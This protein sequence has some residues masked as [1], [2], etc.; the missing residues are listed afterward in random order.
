M[1]ET[2]ERLPARVTMPL[3]TLITQQSLDEDYLHAAERRA[4]GRSGRPAPEQASPRRRRTAAL[5]VLAVFGV[6]VTTAA[7]QT[8]RNEDVADASRESLVAQVQ[9]QQDA[10]AELADRVVQLRERTASLGDQVTDTQSTLQAVEAE[11]DVLERTTGYA[12]VRGP[13]VRIVVD[14][15]EQGDER[16]RKED[17]FLVINGLWQAG[18]EAIALNG[19]RLS[20]VTSINNSDVAINV[21]SS[22]LLPPYTLSAIGDVRTLQAD[23]LDT[24]T[25]RTFLSYRDQYGF[26]VDIDDDEA[27]ELPAARDERLRNA[28]TLTTDQDGRN[29]GTMP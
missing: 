18:A 23:L 3:L 15:P 14:D 16:I 5:V 28:E 27:I 6:L 12:A 7:V 21:E 11:L 20:T 8:Q 24:A 22:A 1:T 13:G 26:R 10:G 25:F 9:A 2:E 19:H 4:A 29:E 17:L